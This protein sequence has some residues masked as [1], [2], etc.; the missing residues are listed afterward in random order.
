VRA[1]EPPVRQAVLDAGPLPTERNYA[2]ATLNDLVTGGDRA[3]L[4]NARAELVRRIFA[5]SDDFEATG[6]LSHVNKA[7][8]ELGWEAPYSW[9]HRRKP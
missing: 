3:G 4:E 9:K 6:A 5:H 1:P 2:E 8:A 7:L